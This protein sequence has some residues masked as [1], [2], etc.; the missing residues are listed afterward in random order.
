MPLLAGARLAVIDTETTGFDIGHGYELIELAVVD[1]VDGAIASQWASLARPMRPIP[2]GA[3]QVHGIT[4]AMVAAAPLPREV[5]HELV[6]RVRGVPLVFH[7]AAFDLPFLQQMLRGAGLPPL[8]NP[9]IDTYGL[10]RLIRPKSHAL[11][12]LAVD[13]ALPVEPPHRALGDALT[14]ARLLLALAPR[15]EA[16]R[17]A[18]SLAELAAESQDVLRSPKRQATRTETP[19]AAPA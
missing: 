13:L 1:V 6:A 3:A 17:A 12:A 7:N 16:E 18:H 15:W 4:T 10:S 5:A 9:V 8:Q 19:A 14:T 2:W 11:A